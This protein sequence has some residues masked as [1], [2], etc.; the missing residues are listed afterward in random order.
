MTRTW[1][2]GLFT[3]LLTF[4]LFGYNI[5]LQKKIILQE[6]LTSTSNLV[7]SIALD[8]EKDFSDLENTFFRLKNH[9]APFTDNERIDPPA[10]RR[11]I[12]NLI[13]EN[14]FLT[15]LMVI[16]KNGQV[17]HWNN[18]VQK[19]NL[20][21]RQYFLIHQSGIFDGLY[22]DWPKPSLINQGQ[23]IFGTSKAIRHSDQ[24]LIRVLAAIVDLKYFY[25]QYQEMF[26]TPGATLTIS[27]LDGHIYAHI[28]GNEELIGQQLPEFAAEN[29][30]IIDNEKQLSIS[31]RVARYPLMIT[32]EKEKSV[33]LAPWKNSSLSFAMLGVVVSL[34]LF[35]FTYRTA[36]YQRRQ[37]TIEK[38]LRLLA[39]TDP[40]T[41]LV[42]RRH[43]LEQAKLEIKKA[44]RNDSSLSIILIDLDHFKNV[45]DKYGHQKGDEVL[46]GTAET[47]KHCCRETDILSRFGGEEFLLVLPDTDSQGAMASASKICDSLA[48]KTYSHSSGE[49]SV[50]GSFGVAQWMPEET[51]ISSAL[52]RAEAALHAVKNCGRNNVR[53]M[54]NKFG[55]S[56]TNDIVCWLYPK[57][58]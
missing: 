45:N 19:L 33:I 26:T 46:V 37:L 1:A 10:T 18:N 24:S 43:V 14:P 47:F 28:P 50:T 11:V 3:I 54:P 5:Q 34:V 25:R 40:L 38:D 49:F 7:N 13:L 36:L 35:F 8:L 20:S 4:L 31:K 51:D 48:Q 39:I 41:Q 16:D 42:N 29:A 17:I 2:I 6:A 52:Q 58:K 21:Q 44:V 9:L 15:A 30:K 53:W 23:W 55:N 12:D 22:I 32:V 57:T 27:S 56:E